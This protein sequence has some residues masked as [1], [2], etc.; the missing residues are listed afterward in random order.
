MDGRFIRGGQSFPIG[1]RSGSKEREVVVVLSKG[2]AANNRVVKKDLP[3]DLPTSW[4]DQEGKQ[5]DIEWLNN[6]GIKRK[7]KPDFEMDDISEDYEIIVDEAEGTT[8]V[9]Y[10]HRDR[11]VKPFSSEDYGRTP[12][13]QGKISARL[14]LGDPPIGRT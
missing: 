2:M 13:Q 9:Y 10:D 6:F 8:L 5:R 12:G 14:R 1:A 7:G 11:R 4:R 3:D